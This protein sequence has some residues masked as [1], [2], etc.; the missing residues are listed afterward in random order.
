MF[1]HG[2]GGLSSDNLNCGKPALSGVLLQ[3]VC[4]GGRGYSGCCSLL[5]LYKPTFLE[6]F[7]Q[8]FEFF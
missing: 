5:T 1:G 8:L 6:R 3:C 7:A 4:G 2:L